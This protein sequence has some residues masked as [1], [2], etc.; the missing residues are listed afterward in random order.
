MFTGHELRH[1]FQTA[2]IANPD[3][4][5]VCGAFDQM[6]DTNRHF[7]CF[8]VEQGRYLATSWK[9]AAQ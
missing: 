2:G 3:Y 9:L 6:L 1:I 5:P 8:A 7:V 4:L